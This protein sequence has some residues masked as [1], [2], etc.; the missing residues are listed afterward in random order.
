MDIS[1]IK[2]S[3]ETPTGI[4]AFTERGKG[5]VTL[6][7][8]GRPVCDYF[9]NHYVAAVALE[10]RCIVVDLTEN[11]QTGSRNA[12][13]VTFGHQALMIG[14]LID[15]LG[16]AQIDLVTDDSAA[17][18]AR[19]FAASNPQRVRSFMRT[20]GLCFPAWAGFETQRPEAPKA[21]APYR[22]V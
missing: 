20:N 1:A 6:L 15:A 8:H 10:R 11:P 7:L 18:V 5:L 2:R 12:V 9:W 3:L 14:Q 21:A 16:F 4:I 17:R 22:V 19:I 13:V